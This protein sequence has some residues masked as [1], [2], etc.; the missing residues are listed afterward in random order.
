MSPVPAVDNISR[1]NYC[2]IVVTLI[3]FCLLEVLSIVS[4][5]NM[6]AD[7][8]LTVSCAVGT[9]I[10]VTTPSSLDIS[11]RM[12]DGLYGYTSMLMIE[13]LMIADVNNPLMNIGIIVDSTIS[14]HSCLTVMLAMY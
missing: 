4:E 11:V 5:A 14:C 1:Y 13:T 3:F 7:L 9:S 2:C 10:H 12:V 8:L 6:S